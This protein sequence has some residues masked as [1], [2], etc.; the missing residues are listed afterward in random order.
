MKIKR[1]LYSF[2]ALMLAMC[3][4]FSGC[5]DT[6][7]ETPSDIVPFITET[8]TTREADDTRKSYN[9][10]SC[11]DMTDSICYLLIFLDDTESTWTE[12]A[13]T[14]FI[15][16]KFEP[17]LNYLH[18]KAEEYNV[19]LND[20]YASFEKEDKS[21]IVY[22]ESIDADVVTNGSQDGILTSLAVKM[23]YSSVKVMNEALKITHGVDQIAY[24]I[25][26]NKEG[27]SYKHSY[28]KSKSDQFEFCV[29]F[30]KSIKYEN[31]NCSS[32]IAHE[33]LHLFGAEDYYDPYGKYPSRAKLADELYPNDIMKKVFKNINDAEI[34]SYTAYSIGWTDTLPDEC[35]VPE[36]WE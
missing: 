13:K 23:G 31:G 15:E 17:T 35:N 18:K 26:L 25:V 32:V 8:T 12:D 14:E 3:I 29:F 16:K 34:G 24:L 11:Y 20:K 9:V 27:R 19:G 6:K 30:N 2:T 22:G 36:W 1:A 4:L 28:V 5:S 10:G 21:P 33:M 7:I